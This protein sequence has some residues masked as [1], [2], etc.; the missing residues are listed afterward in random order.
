MELYATRK[1]ALNTELLD[2]QNTSLYHISTTR[3]SYL[4]QRTTT[5]TKSTPAESVTIAQIEWHPRL[6][7]TTLHFRGRSMDIKDYIGR[8]NRFRR[9]EHFTSF[10]GHRYQW[11][12]NTTST[13]IHS[14]CLLGQLVDSKGNEVAK[15]HKPIG[16]FGS[17]GPPSLQMSQD[18]L[19]D[20]DEVVLTA[21]YNQAMYQKRMQRA[22]NAA[23]AASVSC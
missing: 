16:S 20:M 10:T 22:N 11:E 12:K 1:D 14:F 4:S 21:I 3:A 7:P 2:L 9:S 23:I 17:G 6:S 15:W 19:G 18:V 5:V 13:R 8:P